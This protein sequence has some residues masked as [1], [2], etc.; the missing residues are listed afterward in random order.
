MIYKSKLFIGNESGPAA[1]ACLVCKR[2]I[3]F[4][5]SN[6]RNETSKLPNNGNKKYLEINKAI[7]NNNKI[8][9]II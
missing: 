3:I 8:L 2:I 4:L 1:L 7:K 6:V 5:N 9:N